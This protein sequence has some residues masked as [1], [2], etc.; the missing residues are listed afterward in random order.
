MNLALN[1]PFLYDECK[2]IPF[3]SKNVSEY[4]EFVASS[5]VS[6]LVQGGPGHQL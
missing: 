6:E 4:V 2:G 1:K 5:I 3:Q